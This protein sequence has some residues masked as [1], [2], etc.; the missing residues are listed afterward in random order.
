MTVHICCDAT[1]KIL[2]QNASVTDN[3]SHSASQNIGLIKF[4]LLLA[5]LESMGLLT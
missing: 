2:R 5:K 1:Q 4:Y 3:A